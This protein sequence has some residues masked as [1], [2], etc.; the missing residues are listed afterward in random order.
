MQMYP[1]LTAYFEHPKLEHLVR[2]GFYSL[3]S[4]FAYRGIYGIKLDES[5]NRTHR[6]L[7]VKAEDVD[8][9]RHLDVS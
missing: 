6:I 2:V 7:G 9:L 5:Q 3:A 4:D 8:F 1:F